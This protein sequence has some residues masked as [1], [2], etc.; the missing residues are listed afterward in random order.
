MTGRAG[1]VRVTAC[2]LGRTSFR[3]PIGSGL[4]V[5]L[6]GDLLRLAPEF[7]RAPAGDVAD[8]ELRVVPATERE[9]LPRHRDADIDAHHAGAGALDHPAGEPAALGEDGRRVAVG[10]G[11]LDAD[12]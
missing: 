1:A 7:D 4:A 6:G 3:H 5:P 10:R 9:R 12:R 11:V 2:S 8:P